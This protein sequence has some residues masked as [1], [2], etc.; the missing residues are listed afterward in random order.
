MTDSDFTALPRWKTGSR[1]AH[2]YATD[3]S[4]GTR[5]DVLDGNAFDFIGNPA[6]NAFATAPDLV[7]FV[8]ALSGDSLLNAAYREIFLTAK[9]PRPPLPAKPPLPAVTPFEGYGPSNFVINGRRVAGH[10]GAAP[11]VSTGVDWYSDA[12]LTVV[13]LSNYDPSPD[14]NVNQTLRGILTS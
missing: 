14:A 6:G 12:S 8:R 11:G 7:R 2:P 9:L 4:S 3:Q 5:S 13:S 1:Y 10:L